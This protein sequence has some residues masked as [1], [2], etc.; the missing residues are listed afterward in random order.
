MQTTTI[1]L[2]VF[3]FGRPRLRFRGVPFTFGARKDAL[4][5]LV[6][7]L[8][9]RAQAMSR[10]TVA[11]ALW[12]DLPP[13]EART[14]L[15]ANLHALLATGLP[16]RPEGPWI[17]ADRRALQ[18]NGRA[19]IRLDI[20]E[21]ERL[22]EQPGASAQAVELYT[23]ELAEGLD[24]DWLLAPRDRLREEQQTALLELVDLCHKSDDCRQ[25]IHYVQVLLKLDPFREDAIRTLMELRYELADRAG[26]IHV[27]HEFVRRIR[28]ELD[29]EPMMETTAVYERIAS[30]QH[31]ADRRTAG[32]MAASFL[33]AQHNLPSPL[34]S[35]L[36]RQ[37]DVEALIGLVKQRRLITLTGPG[38]IGKTRLAWQTGHAVLAEFSDGVW[39]VELGGLTD[40]RLVLE[41]LA[42]TL[43][44]GNAS[45]RTS[46][47]AL[48][49][50]SLLLILDN[51]E[52]VIDAV[53]NVAK[54]ILSQCPRVGILATS[55][56]ALRI[57]GE[58]VFQVEPLSIP[59]NE[60]TSLPSIE[61]FRESAA[62]RLFFER[63]VDISPTFQ[64]PKSAHDW[65]TLA[66]LMHHLDGIPLAIELAAAR[67]NALSIN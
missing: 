14:R 23:G 19:Q 18:W 62:V 57:F 40:P 15:R 35:F 27:Y 17:V 54:D 51:C 25:A 22:L 31:L 37:E 26:A 42:E 4:A 46:F 6:Y 28:S 30:A 50:K 63:A 8:I 33:R 21:F 10:D 60:P 11:F 29:A 44:M 56:E 58:R 2:E 47:I 3:L 55:R 48:Q 7:L 13:A 45:Q 49:P 41:S 38:G 64:A 16:R 43:G 52:H 66:S 24:D 1:E 39:S 32:P 53:R 59:I 36:D 61:H 9:H 65:R 67:S 34:T 12:P 5:L 20:E